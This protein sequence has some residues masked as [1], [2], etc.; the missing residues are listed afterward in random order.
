M[1]VPVAQSPAAAV[2][3]RLTFMQPWLSVAP[4]SSGSERCVLLQGVLP[5]AHEAMAASCTHKYNL[6]FLALTQRHKRELSL[7]EL[8]PR[9]YIFFSEDLSRSREQL[10]VC[11]SMN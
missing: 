7:P 11:V 1:G 10:S 5:A 3:T 6:P 9:C 8:S 2:T 4:W